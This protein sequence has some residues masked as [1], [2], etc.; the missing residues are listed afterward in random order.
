MCVTLCVFVCTCSACKCLECFSKSLC[1][2]VLSLGKCFGGSYIFTTLQGFTKEWDIASSCSSVFKVSVK[3][4]AEGH[5]RER[6]RKRGR[7]GRESD[8]EQLVKG[9]TTGDKVM[10]EKITQ[11]E[12]RCVLFSK[13]ENA[14][15]CPLLLLTN[16]CLKVWGHLEMSSV[17]N[18]DAYRC[19]KQ[20]F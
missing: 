19:W 17:D 16:D 4:A 6:E 13:M 18:S 9:T 12:L 1:V 11:D 2:C 3:R 15:N 8:S 5:E 7:K 20:A 10:E 14:T